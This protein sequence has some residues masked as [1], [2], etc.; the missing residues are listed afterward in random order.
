MMKKFQIFTLKF[1]WD[2]SKMRYFSNKFSKIANLQ[3]LLTFN[4]DD[5][6]LRDLPKLCFSYWLWQNRTLKNQLWCHYSDVIVITSPK[7]HQANDT[8]FFILPP[9][10]H[11]NG[12]LSQWDYVI[13]YFDNR[14]YILLSSCQ[15]C[16]LTPKTINLLFG[17]FRKL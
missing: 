17:R 12:W 15:T 10:P 4:F 8:R 14:R 1:S 3:R 5:L 2:M 11:Q 13:V 7:I 6:T 9:L 16:S